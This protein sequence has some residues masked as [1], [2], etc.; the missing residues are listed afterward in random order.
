[1]HGLGFTETE[2][3]AKEQGFVQDGDGKYA[4]LDG[5]GVKGEDDGRQGGG[6]SGGNGSKSGN[7]LI[8]DEMDHKSKK[9]HKE[10]KHKDKDKKH[11]KHK[12]DKEEKHKHRD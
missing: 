3:A 8:I 7:G 10:K 1:V 9:I 4:K 11:K 5:F 2:K 12:K 6:V